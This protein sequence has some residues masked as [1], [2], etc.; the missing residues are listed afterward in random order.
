MY[1]EMFHRTESCFGVYPAYQMRTIMR[2]RDNEEMCS[3]NH[4]QE[5]NFGMQKTG[6]EKTIYQETGDCC[7][8]DQGTVW[9]HT[10][11]L[12]GRTTE[13]KVAEL[14][15]EAVSVITGEAGRCSILH[16]VEHLWLGSRTNT[17]GGCLRE[18]GQRP[19]EAD[20]E[21]VPVWTQLLSFPWHCP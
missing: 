13:F 10:I 11:N 7:V 14:E 3:Q 19:R 1:P 4:L 12:F 5:R 18:Q 8:G 21:S 2:N 17:E 20:P 9:G 15:P 16:L 6:A